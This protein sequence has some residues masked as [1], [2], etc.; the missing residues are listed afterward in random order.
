MLCEGYR[1]N[2]E[3]AFLNKSG[4]IAW[5]SSGKESSLWCEPQIEALRAYRGTSMLLRELGVVPGC[6]ASSLL[7]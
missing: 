6:S 7:V 3:Y 1:Q 5:G 2:E 4:T